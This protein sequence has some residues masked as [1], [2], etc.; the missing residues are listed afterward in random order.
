MCCFKIFHKCSIRFAS[1]VNDSNFYRIIKLADGVMCFW[2]NFGDAPVSIY[3][4]EVCV[5]PLTNMILSTMESSPQSFYFAKDMFWKFIS[6]SP[7]SQSRPSGF[8]NFVRASQRWK[9]FCITVV[10]SIDIKHFFVNWN[11]TVSWRTRNRGTE[12]C[13]F[14]F[15]PYS[16]SLLIAYLLCNQLVIFWT[17]C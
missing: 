15:K 9:Q 5:T 8:H 17:N 2:I 4:E 10:H 1:K 7:S 13:R 11:R 3:L 12:H 6:I 16:L 14:C